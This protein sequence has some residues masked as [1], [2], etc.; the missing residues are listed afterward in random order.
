MTKTK[1]TK[2][3]FAGSLSMPS[4]IWNPDKNM[5]KMIQAESDSRTGLFSAAIVSIMRGLGWKEPE[6]LVGLLV[7]FLNHFPD[8]VREA[9]AEGIVKGLGLVVQ[10]DGEYLVVDTVQIANALAAG[11]KGEKR[12]PGGLILPG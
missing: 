10:R 12:T 4:D 5:F 3:K 7:D 2:F 8:E 11:K 1:P 9:F 6:M